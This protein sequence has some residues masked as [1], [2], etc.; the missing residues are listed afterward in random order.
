MELVAV[1]IRNSKNK[2]F[3]HKRKN[4]KKD[5]PNLFALGVG[6]HVEPTEDKDTAAQRE[7]KEEANL[8]NQV[9]F[10][11]SQELNYIGLDEL[12]HIYEIKSDL[13]IDNCDEEWSWSGWMDKNEIEI[14]M[15]ENKFCPDTTEYYKKY[16]NLTTRHSEFI[17]KS[18][19]NK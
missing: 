12:V 15:K 8:D 3:V 19:G 5:H 4:T 6:G 7:L 18:K 1:V 16:K 14:L 17:S 9:K 11:F 2:Y 10:L 13:A